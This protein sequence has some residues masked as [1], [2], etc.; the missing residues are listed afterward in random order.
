MLRYI[1]A[2]HLEGGLA[3]AHRGVQ[4]GRAERP[5]GRA[6]VLLPR[7]WSGSGPRVTTLYVRA[8]D[9]DVRSPS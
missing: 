4:V 6:T 2:V 3:G 8:E 9:G 1:T 5:G 7:W